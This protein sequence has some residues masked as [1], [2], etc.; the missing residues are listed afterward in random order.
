MNEKIV[1]KSIWENRNKEVSGDNAALGNN[2]I[3]AG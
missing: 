2:K 1:Q 3:L